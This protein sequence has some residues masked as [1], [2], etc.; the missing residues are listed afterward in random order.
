MGKKSKRRSSSSVSGKK[1][2]RADSEDGK[3]LTQLFEEG[4]LRPGDPPGHIKEHH[5]RFKKY[6]NDSFASGLRRLK[7]KL[8]INERPPPGEGTGKLLA[9]IRLIWICFYD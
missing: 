7:I 9:C 6:K 2:W 3:F 4:K 1:G 5:P 8:G